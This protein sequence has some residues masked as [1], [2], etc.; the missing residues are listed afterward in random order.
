MFAN[1]NLLVRLDWYQVR[2]SCSV[3]I[4]AKFL[5][6]YSPLQASELASSIQLKW[7]FSY[8]SCREFENLLDK[9]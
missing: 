2:S 4:A 1:Q 8:T 7:T 3:Q 5:V 6:D 9:R